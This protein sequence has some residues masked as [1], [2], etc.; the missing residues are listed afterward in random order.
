MDRN[1][2]KNQTVRKWVQRQACLYVSLMIH[3]NENG[4]LHKSKLKALLLESGCNKAACHST[5]SQATSLLLASLGL[6]KAETMGGGP[7]QGQ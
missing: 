3:G 2:T 1:L 7:E 6:L 5:S 4:F